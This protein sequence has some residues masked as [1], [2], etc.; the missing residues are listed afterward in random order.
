MHMPGKSRDLTSR[1]GFGK[2]HEC[3][4]HRGISL[5]AWS[6]ATSSETPCVPTGGP[7]GGVALVELATTRARGS[8]VSNPCPVAATARGLARD[9]Q[10]PSMRSR[11]RGCASL[12]PAW[13]A[14]WERRVDR[15]DGKAT[16]N[17]AVHTRSRKTAGGRWRM[18]SN[19]PDTLDLVDA[20]FSSSNYLDTLDLVDATFSSSTFSSS[21]RDV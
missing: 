14:L 17:R 2:A 13:L 18:L 10:S 7:C 9:R 15:N 4:M 16:E 6:S 5:A 12:R 8:C 19:Y 3:H 21:V 1:D 20:T 11:V